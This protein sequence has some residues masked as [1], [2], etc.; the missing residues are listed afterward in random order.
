MTPGQVFYAICNADAGVRTLIGV[1]TSPPSIRLYPSGNL[2][3]QDTT[4]AAVLPAATYQTIGGKP[5]NVFELHAPAD[6]ERIQVDCWSTDQNPDQAQALADAIRTAMENQ[7]QQTS[8]GI[9]ACVVSFNGHDYES[10][11]K[12]YRSS[13]DLSIWISR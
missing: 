10:E 5:A 3:Q 6:N 7:A 8:Y 4:A 11:T 1:A 13:F 2:P 9:G 12:R